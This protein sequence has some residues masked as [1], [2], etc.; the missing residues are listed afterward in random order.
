MSLMIKDGMYK[1][2]PVVETKVINY[3]VY[4][5]VLNGTDLILVREPNVVEVKEEVKV[6][7]TKEKA[8]KK[9]STT[10]K[11]AE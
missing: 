3:R 10:R 5:V 6:V 4:C 8:V 1:G 2:C 7:E 9:P 11:K